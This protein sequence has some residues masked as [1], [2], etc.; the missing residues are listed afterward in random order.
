MIVWEDISE[1]CLLTY[2]V[3]MALEVK[4]RYTRVNPVNTMFSIYVH[5][6]KDYLPG[7]KLYYKVRAL[8][9]WNRP[10]NY[11]DP[12]CSGCSV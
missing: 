9:Y 6:Y 5:W 3:A 7:V 1:R 12:V 2:E 4:G 11:S 8:D 10:G